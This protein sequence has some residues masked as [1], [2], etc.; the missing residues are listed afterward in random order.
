M[1]CALTYKA[2]RRHRARAD[3]ADRII[4]DRP[5]LDAAISGV[6]RTYDLCDDSASLVFGK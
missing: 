4:I 2:D 3:A 6:N 5:R 1:R